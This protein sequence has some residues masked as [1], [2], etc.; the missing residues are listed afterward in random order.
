MCG[1]CWYG[2]FHNWCT[3]C[4]S[5]GRNHPTIHLCSPKSLLEQA[6]VKVFHNC[7]FQSNEE[8][9]SS[10]PEDLR[11]HLEQMIQKTLGILTDLITNKRHQAERNANLSTWE[12]ETVFTLIRVEHMLCCRPLSDRGNIP[13]ENKQRRLGVVKRG[14]YKREQCTEETLL[15]VQ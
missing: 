5:C 10:I 12:V 3:P 7:F 11:I 14:C 1:E 9:W 6:R 2:N 13:F 15:E 8:W 4:C